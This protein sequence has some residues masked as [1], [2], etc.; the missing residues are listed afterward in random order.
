M[1]ILLVDD[2][3]SLMSVLAESLIKQRYA[4][5]L[6]VDGET[7]QEFIEL[8][9]YDLI[10][11]DMLLPD[12]HGVSLCKQLRQKGLS[13]PI[14]ML[15]ASD[16]ST[17]KVNA[18]DSGADDYV[19]KPF[20]LDELLAR[21]RALLRRDTLIPPSILS[22]GELNLHPDTFE[23]FYQDQKLHTTPK[24]YALLE[25]FLRHTHRVFSLDAIIENLW[26]FD[27]PPSG[28]AVRTH[29]K[30]LRQ[31]LRACGAPKDFI[32]TVYGLGYRLKPF[33]PEASSAPSS[34]KAEKEKTVQPEIA[35]AVAK[36]WEAH[37]ETMQERLNV[38]EATAA[39]LVE[40]KLSAE[41]QQSG[42]SHA[43]K[44][45]GSLGCFGF[46]EGSRLARELEKIL[47]LDVPLSHHHVSKVSIL[48]R[49]LRQNL[50]QDPSH[51]VI[52]EAIA[53]APE[54]LAIGAEASLKPT[55]A[56]YALTLGMG[57]STCSNIAQATDQIKT[58]PPNGIVLWL[59][60]NTMPDTLELLGAIAQHPDPIPTLVVTDIQ[61]FQQRLQLV[62]QGVDHI[63]PMSATPQHII[64]AAQHALQTARPVYSILIVDDDR[65]ILNFVKTVLSPWG[66]QITTIDTPDQLWSKLEAIHPDLL[67]LDVEMPQVSGLE[68]CQ[69]LR[70]D[71]RWQQLPILFLT[72]HE[73]AKTQHQAFTIGAD[74]FVSKS[75]IA[76]DLPTRIFNRLR[77]SHSSVF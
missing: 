22:W 43:H 73:D 71:E 37:R 33:A 30:G 31:K 69:V 39:A 17:D 2:D 77:R 18:L 44:L 9:D 3:E 55:L 16:S 10:V 15:T 65:Q 67:I 1:R 25:L 51:T 34:A 27:D 56:T 57:F 70:A 48:V 6:A 45:A 35:A 74:D 23:V 53:S 21:I 76:T 40:G 7:A 12:S 5:D 26:S 13:R 29:I 60:E 49:D 4:V 24:E 41:L 64:H 66:F 42:R 46:S 36:A 68:L 58:H 59:D 52:S 11:L 47:Q 32:E 62:Q 8:F 72:V 75:A 63:L 61:D 50:N 19:V 38:L 54:L 20:D 28:D 14:L